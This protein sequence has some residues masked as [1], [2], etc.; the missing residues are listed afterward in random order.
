[1]ISERSAG[2][3][4]LR[5]TTERRALELSG[6]LWIEAERRACTPAAGLQAERQPE[7]APKSH[8]DAV[9]ALDLPGFHIAAEASLA[10]VGLQEAGDRVRP[11]AVSGIASLERRTAFVDVVLRT[12]RRRRLLIFRTQ[13]RLVGHV[14][15]L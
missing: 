2:N 12:L 1:V 6:D 11:P 3:A 13:I 7:F 14:P 9:V 5:G 10:H 4:Q 15:S 8:A